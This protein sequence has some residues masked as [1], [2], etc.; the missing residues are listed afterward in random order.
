M[1][2]P[3]AHKAKPRR[4]LIVC[5][6][7]LLLTGAI[8]GLV[9]RKQTS[10]ASHAQNADVHRPKLAVTHPLKWPT[11]AAAAAI[12]VEDYGV[13]AVHGDDKKRP[14][15]SIAKVITCLAILQKYP[16]KPGEDGPTIPITE[17]D[18]QLYR[19]YIAKNGTVVSIK[20]GVPL[21]LRQA[22]QA[23]LL[24]SANN[25]A[26][27]TAIWAFGSLA[28]YRT[29]ANAMLQRLELKDT[30]VGNDASGLDPHTQSTARD[31]IKLGE[32][33]LKNPV[34]AK[35]MATPQAELPFAGTIVNG[36]WL[37]TRHG[38][39]GIKPGDSNEAGVTL[40]FS[41]KHNIGGKNLNLIGVI[42]G[43]ESYKSSSTGALDLIDSARQSITP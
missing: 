43:A 11:D 2:F 23:M 16:L 3:H 40:L 31:L 22:V 21:T 33:A 32:L 29:Y 12:G 4:G 14:I 20:A 13:V 17:K 24:P 6:I 28:R 1:V 41:T 10:F 5:G 35:E 37:V 8:A 39:T 19:D 30:V 42:L 7:C 15:A 26:D 18:E 36:N 27:T 9:W 34:I 25:V 38:F